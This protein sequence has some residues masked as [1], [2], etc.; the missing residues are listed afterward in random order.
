MA[1]FYVVSRRIKRREGSCLLTV[2]RDLLCQYFACHHGVRLFPRG[3]YGCDQHFVS[4]AKR[5]SKLVH[6]RL[7]AAIEMRVKYDN[8][9]FVGE[10][11]SHAFYRCYYFSWMVGI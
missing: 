10:L 6:K 2:L 3:K 4:I 5:R 1:I 7:G 9:L 11:L 8:Y